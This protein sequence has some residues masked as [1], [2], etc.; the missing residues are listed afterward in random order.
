M[1]R[2]RNLAPPSLRGEAVKLLEGLANLGDDD[3]SYD[4]LRN[5]FPYIFDSVSRW[6]VRHWATNSEGP[7][8]EPGRPDEEL[9][10]QYWLLPLRGSLRNLW[11]APDDW[12]KEWGMFRVS[13]EFFLQGVPHLIEVP[14]TNPSEFLAGLRPPGRTEQ[15]LLQLVRMAHLTRYC[16]NPECTAPYFI[17]AKRSLKYCSDVCSRYGQRQHKLKWWNE[18]GDASRKAGRRPRNDRR[19]AAM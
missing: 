19:D 1:I 2:K 15:L 5:N 11:R 16:G 3:K 12:T 4:W 10:R 17:A 9:M 7:Y 14:L 18:H 8:Y 6:V 13:Q